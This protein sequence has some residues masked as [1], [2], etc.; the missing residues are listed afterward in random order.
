M[1]KWFCLRHSLL[2]TRCPQYFCVNKLRCQSILEAVVVGFVGSLGRG[3]DERRG[4]WLLFLGQQG[5]IC[6]QRV[7]RQEC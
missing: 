3:V 4:E 1:S 5:G 6:D 7:R 2:Q